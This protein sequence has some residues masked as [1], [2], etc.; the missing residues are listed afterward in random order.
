MRTVVVGGGPAGMI[1]AKVCADNGDDVVLLEK[2]EML[3]KKIFV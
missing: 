1:A 3:G 2:N